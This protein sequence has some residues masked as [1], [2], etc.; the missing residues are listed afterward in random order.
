MTQPVNQSSNERSSIFVLFFCAIIFLLGRIIGDRFFPDSWGFSHWE[1]ISLISIGLWITVTVLIIWLYWR[2]GFHIDHIFAKT[3]NAVIGAILLFLL[4]LIFQF[5]SF[6]MAGGNERIAQIGQADVIILQHHEYGTLLV[7]SWLNHV[8]GL[9][10]LPYNQAAV[11]AWKSLA[12]ICT[13]L[14]MF[15]AYRLAGQLAGRL[16]GRCALFTI[17]FFGPQFI[18]MF[19]FIGIEPVFVTCIIC[20]ASVAYDL[21]QR[22]RLQTLLLL[23]VLTAFSIFMQLH[24]LILLPPLIYNAIRATSH[25]KK[26]IQ[27]LATVM[28]IFVLVAMVLILY[29]KTADNFFMQRFFLSLTGKNP[30]AD[31]G[32]F[33]SRHLSDLLQLL[34]LCFP[35]IFALKFFGLS[36]LKTLFRQQHLFTLYLLWAGGITLCIILDPGNSMLLDLPRYAGY[37]TP[38]AILLAAL[39]VHH[40]SNQPP[41]H[42]HRLALGRAGYL[43]AA[44]SLT[45]PFAY[46]PTYL[47]IDTSESY[48]TTYL[49]QH[50]AYYLAATISFR[51]AYFYKQDF[52]KANWWDQN[53]IIKSPDYLDLLGT[54]QV[55]QGQGE[56]ESIRT[57]GKL[58][59]RNPYWVAPRSF[60]ASLQ[61]KQG[62]YKLA[63]PQIDTALMLEPFAKKTLTNAFQYYRD[64][65]NYPEAIRFIEKAL[66]Y[67]PSDD[68][69]KVDLMIVQY[70]AGN[71]QVADSIANELIKKKP[72]SPYPYLI[73]GFLL[74]KAGQV[75]N[76]IRLYLKFV[77]LGKDEADRPAIEQRIERLRGNGSDDG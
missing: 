69:L 76:A 33:S 55:A 13:I 28:S 37:L 19:G 17:I 63:K 66:S 31:Y 54:E 65:Q 6:L 75:D 61:M 15:G 26:S 47:H 36:N 24:L 51:D 7:V 60:Y 32:L 49:D 77:E 39:L 1:S 12:F 70:R 44:M 68:E 52:D 59:A 48:A 53:Y 20:F 67:Y 57:L 45:F 72:E 29:M 34:L 43:A 2:F 46:M 42:Q 50:D 73:K 74:E 25:G 3:R 35:M 64:I 10:G 40:A 21:Q 5:D 23:T 18:L 9:I 4:L 71:G 16:V 58:I 8:F 27:T 22:A 62:Q 11:Y 14:S 56:Y 30:H 41:L 38:G